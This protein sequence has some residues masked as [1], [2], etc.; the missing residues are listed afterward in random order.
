MR[1]IIEGKRMAKKNDEFLRLQIYYNVNKIGRF[2]H[3]EGIRLV[4][5]TGFYL[6][7]RQLLPVAPKGRNRLS[8]KEKIAEKR[9]YACKREYR[10]N[11]IQW[12]YPNR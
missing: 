9:P 4:W 10:E 2:Q 5:E 3:S 12:G 7:F 11:N 6:T 8:F 1:Y